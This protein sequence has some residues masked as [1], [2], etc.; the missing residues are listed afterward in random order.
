MSLAVME[1][2]LKIVLLLKLIQRLFTNDISTSDIQVI[3]TNFS[4]YF[5]HQ[6]WLIYMSFLSNFDFF[7]PL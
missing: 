2:I 3:S 6:A 7:N 1:A 4:T 5:Q